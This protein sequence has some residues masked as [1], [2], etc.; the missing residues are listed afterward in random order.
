MPKKSFASEVDR[1]LSR[2]DADEMAEAI[3]AYAKYFDDTDGEGGW[4]EEYSDAFGEILDCPH[5]NP[6]KALAYVV[7]GA[8]RSDN[9]SFVAVMACGSLEDLL[10][11]PTDEMIE[12]VI[13]E[14]RKSPRFRWMLS[15]P[16]KVAVSESA[17]RA[18]EPFRIT[19]PHEEPP[20]ETMPANY[21]G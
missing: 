15:H 8:A 21:F 3:D 10:R 12:R 11:E 7:L 17:W 19:G 6:D 18:I 13:A 16:F 2:T 9:P 4:P 14:A 5:D 20:Y 1:A